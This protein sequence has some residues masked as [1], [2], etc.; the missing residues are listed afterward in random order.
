LPFWE[1]VVEK[2]KAGEVRIER[3]DAI[4]GCQM[5]NTAV[6]IRAICAKVRCV[7]QEVHD[8]ARSTA[9]GHIKRAIDFP[10]E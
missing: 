7:C 3:D 2:L 6:D 5:K 10:I 1:A 9:R 8:H 4:G